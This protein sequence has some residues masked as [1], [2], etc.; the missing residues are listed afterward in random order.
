MTN[1]TLCKKLAEAVGA[2]DSPLV[3]KIFEALV[4]DDEA[5]VLLLASPPATAE[6]L[7]Q[8]SGLPLEAI[9]TMMDSLFSRG[10]IFKATRGGEKKFYR[11][12][13]IPQMHDSTSLT[14]GISR[15]ILDLWKEYMEKE[16]P[17]YGGK[18]MEILPGS[19]MRVVPVNESVE[20]QSRV[21]AYEDVEKI[22]QDAKVLSVTN[23]S[24][25]VISGNCDKPLEVCMQVDRA[26]EYN[27]ERGTGR[28]LSKSEAVEIL[29]KCREEGL[30]HVVDNRQVVG[31]VI[32]NCCKDCCLNWAVMKGPK[33]WVAPSRYEA[34]VDRDLC[35]GCEACLD[36]CFFDALSLEDELAIVDPE[37]CLGCGVCTVVC[38]TEALKLKETRPADFVPA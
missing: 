30:V 20:V 19:I 6:D 5:K 32:C 12:K 3:P 1:A 9:E 34:F 11:V 13:T 22:V 7:A 16:W 38:P 26:A 14:P 8:K 23:C 25:R 36:R 35:S 27:I 21:L 15:Q 10:L 31:H 2:G 18:I 33:K 37:K 17:A 29:K 24:C 4:S 28:A